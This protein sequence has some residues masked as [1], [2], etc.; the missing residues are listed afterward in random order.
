VLAT[1]V[2]LN[3]AGF[4]AA[5]APLTTITE[6]LEALDAGLKSSSLVLANATYSANAPYIASGFLMPKHSLVNH[7]PDPT[8]GRNFSAFAAGTQVFGLDLAGSALDLLQVTVVGGSGTLAFQQTLQSFGNCFGVEDDLGLISVRFLN[9][10]VT[11]SGGVSS[12]SNYAFDN[13]TTGAAAVPEPGALALMTLALLALGASTSRRR[14]TR[15]D[16]RRAATLG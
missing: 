1:P 6:T 8:S 11:Y 3:A 14:H 16:T 12:M 9:L 5:L 2:V 13:V 15:A 4:A 7:T 10:G